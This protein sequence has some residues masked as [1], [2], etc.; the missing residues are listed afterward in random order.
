MRFSYGTI[1]FISI[2]SLLNN[3]ERF[4][5][6]RYRMF[7]DFSFDS[8]LLEKGFLHPLHEGSKKER[9][10]M[11]LISSQCDFLFSL[12]LFVVPWWAFSSK[13]TRKKK[14][15]RNQKENYKE[16][17]MKIYLFKNARTHNIAAEFLLP[18]SAKYEWECK[19]SQKKSGINK[20]LKKISRNWSSTCLNMKWATCLLCVFTVNML[21][22]PRL[23]MHETETTNKWAFNFP[24]LYV[25]IERNC[26]KIVVFFLSK[27]HCNWLALV[28]PPCRYLP[29]PI[30]AA[31]SHRLIDNCPPETKDNCSQNTKRPI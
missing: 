30:C 1:P 21:T 7:T 20:H 4:Q 17:K 8:Y 2:R 19:R 24:K 26:R 3:A 14:K 28:R 9:N 22:A 5:M 15:Y 23:S 16:I 27:T 11:D 29:L 10:W 12:S 18:R 25:Y 6:I 31:V 13:F